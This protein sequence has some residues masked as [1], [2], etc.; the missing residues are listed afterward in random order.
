M[1]RERAS[2]GTA[3][4][5]QPDAESRAQEVEVV[6]RLSNRSMGVRKERDQIVALEDQLAEVLERTGAGECEGD[7]FGEGECTIYFT[8]PDAERLFLTLQPHLQKSPLC[9]GA[10]AIKRYGCT[11]EAPQERVRL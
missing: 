8:G 6:L 2:D 11:D 9:R 4:G 7:E 5:D 1:A 10:H 3:D